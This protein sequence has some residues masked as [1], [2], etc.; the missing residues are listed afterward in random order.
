MVILGFHR[1]SGKILS[2]LGLPFSCEECIN[3]HTR[4]IRMGTK[5]LMPRVEQVYGSL[6]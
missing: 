4:L 1:T 2:K 3:V 5:E 6:I